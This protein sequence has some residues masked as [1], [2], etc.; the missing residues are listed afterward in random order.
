LTRLE[1]ETGSICTKML[2]YTGEIERNFGNSTGLA[3]V[4]VSFFGSNGESTSMGDAEPIEQGANRSRSGRVKLP[5][6][7]ALGLAT[8]WQ[9]QV[10]EMSFLPA[11]EYSSAQNTLDSQSDPLAAHDREFGERSTV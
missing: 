9:R 1:P 5:I 7:V 4:G 11:F 2:R 3:L 8:L 10:R 6:G